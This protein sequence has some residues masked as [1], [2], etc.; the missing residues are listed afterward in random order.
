VLVVR[1]LVVLHLP[2]LNKARKFVM[3]AMPLDE[4]AICKARLLSIIHIPIFLVLVFKAQFI[5]ASTI[6]LLDLC[7]CPIQSLLMYISS[8]PLL[9]SSCWILTHLEFGKQ[10]KVTVFYIFYIKQG[11]AFF[12]L[13][14]YTETILK[15]I[16]RKTCYDNFQVYN[17][18]L[19][20]SILV[21]ILYSSYML[22]NKEN[23]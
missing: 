10:W 16:A 23:V 14:I 11:F 3:F 7:Q 15:N 6:I 1:N 8:S 17:V 12:I 9:N 5:Y 20:C 21:R 19:I 18:I 2:L 22:Y 4:M 13:K